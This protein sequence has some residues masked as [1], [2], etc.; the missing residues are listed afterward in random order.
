MTWIY[1][2]DHNK[3]I[4]P[5]Q[6]RN[7]FQKA[8]LDVLTGKNP[9][10][11]SFRLKPTKKASELYPIKLT[12]QQRESL[13]HCTRIKL[14]VKKKI[15]EAGEG[16]Q[17]VGFTRKELDHLNDEI[18]QAAYYALSPHK[19]RLMSVQSKVGKFFEEEHK[20]VFG[21]EEPASRKPRLA[22]SGLLYQFKI[23]LLGS[24]P[25]IWR[26]IQVTDCTLDKL[27]EHIQTAMGWENSHLHQFSIAGDR[28]GDPQLLGGMDDI[29][30]KNSR[31]TKL[32]DILPAKG[33]KFRFKY[34]YDFGD[35]WEHEVLFEG[36][37]EPAKGNNYPLCL[38]GERACPPED[39]GGIW[40]YYDLLAALADP[41]HEQHDDFMEW[42]GEIDP[43]K[44]D[45]KQATK[46]MKKGL[47][48]WRS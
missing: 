38:E 19:K 39:C 46:E 2:P 34:E 41:T 30:I 31:K 14:S 20:A 40:G 37:P 17:I 15:E 12:P 44:F 23:T 18:G 1:D 25:P 26:R 33:Q 8:M 13:I 36:C 42:I 7:K 10:P 11:Q 29:K 6:A 27:H 47:P 9:G 4:T 22:K 35:G 48:D 28:Y 24:K 43:E 32:S 5:Q 16:T 45:A 21:I 3:R